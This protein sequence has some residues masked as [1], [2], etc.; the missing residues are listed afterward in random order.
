MEGFSSN[1]EEFQRLMDELLAP[2]DLQ[3]FPLDASEYSEFIFGS[4]L[5]VG[6]DLISEETQEKIEPTAQQSSNEQDNPRII[7]LEA[8]CV[9]PS[10]YYKTSISL[11]ALAE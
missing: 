10:Y 6:A 7:Q 11:I 4:G 1:E 5:N 2:I 8:R 3:S 9:L